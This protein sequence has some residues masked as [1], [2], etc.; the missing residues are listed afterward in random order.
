MLH[1]LCDHATHILN[2]N[3]YSY[4]V[5]NDTYLHLFTRTGKHTQWRLESIDGKY[6]IDP[7]HWIPIDKYPVQNAIDNPLKLP[8]FSNGV[9]STAYKSIIK[10]M[11]NGYMSTKLKLEKQNFQ[12][13]VDECNKTVSQL[14]KRFN[15]LKANPDWRSIPNLFNE[16][17]HLQN[18]VFQAGNK[19]D[20]DAIFSFEFAPEAMLPISIDELRIWCDLN[21]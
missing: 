16:A 19:L 12:A 13:A 11:F 4:D 10:S 15:E 2:K 9:P 1:I 21:G 20:K 18:E 17:E 8:L 5:A 3:G 6:E 14:M 7:S